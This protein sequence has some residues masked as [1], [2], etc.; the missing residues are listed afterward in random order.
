MIKKRRFGF[1]F[2]LITAVLNIACAKQELK[3]IM[4]QQETT[5][6]GYVENLQNAE[7]VVNEGVWRVVLEEGTSGVVAERGDSLVFYYSAHIFA[8]GKGMMFDT[9]VDTLGFANGFIHDFSY[10]KPRREVVG[11]G[12]LMNGLDVGLIG[13][14]KGERCYVIFSARRG[15]GNIQVGMVPKMSPLLYEIWIKEIKKN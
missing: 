7:V 3:N 10:Y 11:R 13:V 6:E 5:I 1:I 15:Y 9:N 14:A 2:V 12:K 8:S 4:T